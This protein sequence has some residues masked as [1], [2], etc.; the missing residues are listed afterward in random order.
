MRLQKLYLSFFIL[1]IPLLFVRG[2]EKRVVF[3]CDKSNNLYTIIQNS[4]LDNVRYDS[5]SEAISNAHEGDVVLILAN[6]YPEE[7]TQMTNEMYRIIG[8]KNIKT[9]IEFP[10]L[11]PN[12]P[13]N[14]ITKAN[15]ERC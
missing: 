5:P 9:F 14:N 15:K 10:S 3:S 4:K 12:I 13:I 7:L 1:F 11:I 8:E 2:N 6:K